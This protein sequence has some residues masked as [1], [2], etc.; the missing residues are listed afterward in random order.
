MDHKSLSIQ[1]F[2]YNLP[3]ERIA[4]HPLAQRDD[5][6]LLI[7]RENS[8]TTDIYKNAANYIPSNALMIFNDTKVVEARLYF[9]KATGGIIEVFCL[10]PDNSY[11][12]ITTAMSQ[13]G[14]VKWICLIKNAAKWHKDTLLHLNFQVQNKEYILEANYLSRTSDS[15]LIELKWNAPI[16]FAEVLHFAGHVPLPPYI[17]RKDET[18][19]KSRYQTVFAEHDGSVA[20]P[21]AGLHFTRDILSALKQ[22]NVQTNYVTLHVGAGTFKPVKA[23]T[24]KDHEMHSE[25]IEVDTVLIQQLLQ[26]ETIPIIAVGTTSLRTLESIYWLGVKILNQS[27]IFDHSLPILTQWEV[28]NISNPANKKEALQALLNYLYTHKLEKLT[29]KTQIIIV[30]EYNFKMVDGLFTNFHQPASTLLLLVAAFIGSEWKK[31]YEYALN[32][33]FRFLSYGDGSLL[34]RNQP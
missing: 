29:A 8:I 3:S 18:A 6:K 21:T 25:F 16:S 7:Y 30:P 15:F 5:S 11:A 31:V 17:K 1:D 32:N 4:F 14:C 2:T 12:D 23:D 10:E 13:T 26:Q 24:M 9:K 27:D 19:D 28:Y 22:K 34:W 33:E 20:A